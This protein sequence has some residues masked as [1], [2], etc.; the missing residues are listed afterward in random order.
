MIIFQI[1]QILKVIRK[2]CNDGN[3]CAVYDECIQLSFDELYEQH[4]TR[5][6]NLIHLFP[7]YEKQVIFG[8]PK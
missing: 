6:K 1:F 7:E 3:G 4:I 2:I 5:I 8:Q